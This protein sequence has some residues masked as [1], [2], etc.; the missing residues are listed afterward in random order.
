MAVAIMPAVTQAVAVIFTGLMQGEAAPCRG[1]PPGDMA[2][3]DTV[4][5]G[6][7]VAGATAKDRFLFLADPIIRPAAARFLDRF[8]S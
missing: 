6:M 3:A 8:R 4:A 7:K 1:F 5:A 2:E